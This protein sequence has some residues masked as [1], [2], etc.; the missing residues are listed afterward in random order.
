MGIDKSKAPILNPGH[1]L[2]NPHIA[3]GKYPSVSVISSFKIKIH[4]SILLL[5]STQPFFLLYWFFVFQPSGGLQDVL[6]RLATSYQY[7]LSEYIMWVLRESFSRSLLYSPFYLIWFW[8]LSI[9]L[10]KKTKEVHWRRE[11]GFLIRILHERR[12]GKI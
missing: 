1:S 8:N 9:W 3:L 6:S 11:W 5:I 10:C 4:A 12:V 7:Q 2:F